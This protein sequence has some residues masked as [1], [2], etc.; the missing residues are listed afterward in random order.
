MVVIHI[1]NM[2]ID[3]IKIIKT[4]GKGMHGTIY[5]VKDNK[6]NKYA[7]KIE[8]VFKK[9]IK[10]SLS[11]PIWREIEFAKTMSKKYPNHFTKLYDYKIVNDC[12][13][14]QNLDLDFVNAMPKA[15][16]AFYK[17]LYASP[18]CSIKLYSL[19]DMTLDDLLNSWKKFDKEF[20]YDLIIQCVYV[21]YL[22]NKEGYFHHDYHTKNIG[23]IKTTKKYIT[24]LNRK[25]RTH[26]VYVVALDYGL[27]LHKKFKLK[28]WEK[29]ALEY[30]ND[31]FIILTTLILPT[32]LSNITSKYKNINIYKNV[33]I[34]DEDKYLL[35]NFLVN[36][37][38]NSSRWNQS[39][40]EFLIQFL[41]KILFFEDF[42][43]SY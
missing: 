6:N 19:I 43:S 35:S 9:D 27:V 17:K 31:I 21:I 42:K 33:K 7:L 28:D 1:D 15:Q 14:T 29:K 37:K 39:T 40:I 11:S 12:K 34:N 8:P 10:K 38:N 23:I 30:D 4:I 18:Y 20:F 32:V 26:G 13:H 25:V 2:S 16:Q 5:L 41:Y 3:N 36:F 22:I 24:I